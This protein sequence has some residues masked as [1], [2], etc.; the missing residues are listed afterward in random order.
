M[1]FKIKIVEEGKDD[2]FEEEYFINRIVFEEW[3]KAMNDCGIGT[4]SEDK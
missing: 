4:F 2:M 3:L 1:L